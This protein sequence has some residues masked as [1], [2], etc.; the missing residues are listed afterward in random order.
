MATS[1][2]L[3]S[4][5]AQMYTFWKTLGSHFFTTKTVLPPRGLTTGVVVTKLHP[6]QTNPGQG[7]QLLQRSLA[8]N[9]RTTQRRKD[10]LHVGWQ[11]PQNPLRKSERFT[12]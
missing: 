10:A 4:L 12:N 3:L 5:E 8:F 6:L 7:Q 2:L 9:F 1:C 11:R